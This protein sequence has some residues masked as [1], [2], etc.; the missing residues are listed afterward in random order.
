MKRAFKFLAGLIAFCLLAFVFGYFDSELSEGRRWTGCI[1]IVAG[2]VIAW[3]AV[4]RLADD[5]PRLKPR[6]NVDLAFAQIGFS[7]V[8]LVV[9][10]LMGGRCKPVFDPLLEPTPKLA[11]PTA[12]P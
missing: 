9:A 11:Q 6:H 10:C 5:W 2:M 8:V 1:L 7:M 12:D 4:V 3:P